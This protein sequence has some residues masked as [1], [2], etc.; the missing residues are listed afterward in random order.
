MLYNIRIEDKMTGQ[1]YFQIADA[2]NHADAVRIAMR[3]LGETVGNPHHFK[4]VK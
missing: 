1:Q 4:E 3:K 2:E